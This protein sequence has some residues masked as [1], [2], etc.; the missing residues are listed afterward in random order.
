MLK[1]TENSSGTYPFF[2]AAETGAPKSPKARGEEPWRP[3]SL[4]RGSALETWKQDSAD[5]VAANQLIGTHVESYG[6]NDE[7]QSQKFRLVLQELV[8]V[9]KSREIRRGQQR[10]QQ[11]VER[12]YGCI[13][14]MNTVGIR[15]TILLYKDENLNL[16]KNWSWFLKAFDHSF[17]IAE[18]AVD[19]LIAQLILL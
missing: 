15:A 11:S 9:C 4:T 12:N 13:R 7:K 8:L 17:E 18:M 3:Q 2:G 14:E 10:G 19:D 16:E 1:P 5:K 6:L